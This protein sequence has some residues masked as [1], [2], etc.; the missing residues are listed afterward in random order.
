MARPIFRALPLASLFSLLGSIALAQ[1]A[2]PV[3][4]QAQI[5]AENKLRAFNCSLHNEDS[6][7]QLRRGE[8]VQV[9]TGGLIDHV[10]FPEN[11]KDADLVR[12]LPS[13]AK[14]PALKSL[15]LGACKLITEKGLKS[16]KVLPKVEVLLLDGSPIETA[17]L[18]ELANVKGLRWLDLSGTNLNDGDMKELGNITTLSSLVVRGMPRLTANG[19]KNIL[20]L[21]KIRYL[22]ITI[23]KSRDQMA[24]T[25]SQAKF[26]ASLKVAPVSDN[27]MGHL[28]K[29]ATLDTLDLSNEDFRF[30]FNDRVNAGK[31]NFSNSFSD[32]GLDKLA[33]CQALR[34][35]DIS[36][37]NVTCAGVSQFTK[38][39]AIEDLYMRGSLCNDSTV[40]KLAT[41]PTLRVLDLRQTG[42]TDRSMADLADLPTLQRLYLANLPLTDSGL[43]DLTRLRSLQ[44]LDLSSTNVSCVRVRD[45][46]NFSQLEHLHLAGTHITT[47]SFPVLASMKSLRFLNLIDNLPEVSVNSIV[48][49]RTEMPTCLIIASEPSPRFYYYG[50]G[51]PLF[52][53]WPGAMNYSFYV[54]PISSPKIT[55]ITTPKTVTV[56]PPTTTVKLPPP[57]PRPPAP[58]P[59]RIVPV[60]TG[61]TGR[62]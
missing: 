40:A 7:F 25:L 41:M 10:A 16:L 60:G 3:K 59:I 34:S 28:G 56:K 38:L 11:T 62:P 49:L 47:A 50:F 29:M 58:P 36:F 32:A 52:I 20:D 42:V 4:T 15:D 33:G 8:R 2:A 13:V 44:V 31:I 48:P 37:V 26:L 6:K 30:G 21:G 51:A 23:E 54:P 12:L 57:P 14:L 9:S 43:Q 61:T 27:E 55:P 39:K 1:P 17:G 19:I 18:K 53:G 35:L 46:K 45:M 5:E 22:D 24:E